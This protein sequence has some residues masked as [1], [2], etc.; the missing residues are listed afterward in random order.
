M[1]EQS[2]LKY[3]SNRFDTVR[4]L[5][6]MNTVEK[7]IASGRIDLRHELGLCSR[8]VHHQQLA[9]E[10]SVRDVI[11]DKLTILEH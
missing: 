9:L 10:R 4:S 7:Q 11:N 2:R 3:L 8:K 6:H 5:Y 1:K